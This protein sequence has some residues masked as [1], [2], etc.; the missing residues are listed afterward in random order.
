MLLTRGTCPG[1]LRGA[2][3]QPEAWQDKAEGVPQARGNGD[4]E[5][6]GNVE[7]RVRVPAT[8]KLPLSESKGLP[9]PGARDRSEILEAPERSNSPMTQVVFQFNLS[10]FSL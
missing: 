7:G 10:K 5:T 2:K 8:R 9:G 3:Q 1:H 4:R 6:T